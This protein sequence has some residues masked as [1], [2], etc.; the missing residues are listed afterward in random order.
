MTEQTR[1]PKCGAL[2]VST[3]EIRTSRKTGK[4]ISWFIN[5]VGG[6]FMLA[7]AFFLGLLVIVLAFVRNE[8]DN[9]SVGILNMLIWGIP[10]LLLVYAYAHGVTS[11]L[12]KCNKCH[13]K[14]TQREED[15]R[16][17]KLAENVVPAQSAPAKS[18]VRKGTSITLWAQ[19]EATAKQL[20]T[21][22]Y[23]LLGAL[24]GDS[25]SVT[26]N[27]QEA[28]DKGGSLSYKISHNSTR[29]GFNVE[30]TITPQVQVDHNV[31]SDQSRADEITRRLAEID[32]ELASE[33]DRILQASQSS[34]DAALGNILIASVYE[35]L[36]EA[37]PS[38]TRGM[39]RITE[40]E[41]ERAKLEAE[42]AKLT[43]KVAQTPAKPPTLH[44]WV[45]PGAEVRL[46]ITK[47]GE[48]GMIYKCE[49][50]VN[51]TLQACP[52]CKT[53]FNSRPDGKIVRFDESRAFPES[54]GFF[55]PACN[56]ELIINDWLN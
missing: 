10:G 41:A 48:Q 8:V 38:G 31:P 54:Q 20:A 17:Q 7:L 35:K 36:G 45:P 16:Q 52:H 21:D 4:T 2:T 22:Q 5:L 3:K 46:F 23:F 1:C 44:L 55:C 53:P 29:G 14:W 33:H 32:K 34:N 27:F 47:A 50:A 13:H 12:F 30:L 42:R 25:S 56:Q 9:L 26:K 28:L 37:S 11:K 6:G 39:E 19:D 40:L 51:I 24:M 43:S 49:G 18:E 15:L